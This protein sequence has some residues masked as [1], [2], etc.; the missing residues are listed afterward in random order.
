MAKYIKINDPAHLA[1]ALAFRAVLNWKAARAKRPPTFA[2]GG[3]QVIGPPSYIAQD[4]GTEY[5]QTRRLS[6]QGLE[7]D[8]MWINEATRF[9]P[10]QMADFKKSIQDMGSKWPDRKTYAEA[11]L[12]GSARIV[13]G[14]REAGKTQAV[15]VWLIDHPGATVIK[16]STLDPDNYRRYVLGDWMPGGYLL[17][18]ED[19]EKMKLKNP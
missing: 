15:K 1:W 4:V 6:R 17:T 7:L 13:R 10:Q 2:N 19:I 18:E 14:G 8:G 5:V 16:E 9:T 12:D 11:L 3:I